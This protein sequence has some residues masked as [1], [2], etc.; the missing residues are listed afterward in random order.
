MGFGPARL[1]PQGVAPVQ[2]YTDRVVRDKRYKLWVLDNQ[3]TRLYD[4]LED[5]E[6]QNNLIESTDPQVV[7]ARA[8]LEAV[9]ASFPEQDAWPRYD[10]TPPQPWDVEP[11]QAE[12]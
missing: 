3:G 2:A 12:Q 1:T 6:E 11:E 5:P 4:L 10:P 7:A 9:V 8:R